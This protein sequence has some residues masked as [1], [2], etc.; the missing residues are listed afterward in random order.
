MKVEIIHDCEVCRHKPI[1]S[2]TRTFICLAPDIQLM[3]KSY[4]KEEMSL[5]LSCHHF[6]QDKPHVK[7]YGYYE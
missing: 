5:K 7:K 4:E 2:Q 6:E 1:C 3:G